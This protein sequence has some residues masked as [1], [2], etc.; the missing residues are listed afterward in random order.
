MRS[1]GFA[2]TADSLYFDAIKRPSRSPSQ[3]PWREEITGAISFL[4]FSNCFHPTKS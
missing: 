1:F 2:H 4:H 3:E